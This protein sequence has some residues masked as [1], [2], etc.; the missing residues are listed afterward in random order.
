MSLPLFVRRAARD[1]SRDAIWSVELPPLATYSLSSFSSFSLM[2]V[3]VAVISLSN[4]VKR[5]STRVV[6]IFGKV[7]V[8]LVLKMSSG[9]EVVACVA[10]DVLVL[11]G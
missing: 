8:V 6:D 9:G 3:V 11:E 1:L 4:L 10:S 2:E 7:V 5:C